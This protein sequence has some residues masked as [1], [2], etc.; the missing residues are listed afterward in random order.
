M[1]GSTVT[2]LR[3][4]TC[5]V[6]ADQVGDA[7]YAPAAGVTVSFAVTS[8][9][10]PPGPPFVDDGK[11]TVR[12]IDLSEQHVDGQLI[13]VKQDVSKAGARASRSGTVSTRAGSGINGPSDL[14]VNGEYVCTANIV[15]GLGSCAVKIK[16]KGALTFYAHYRG[17]VPTGT[18]PV[19]AS[20]TTNAPSNVATVAINT[21]S[22]RVT[23]K[24]CRINLYMYG[25]VFDARRVVTVWVLKDGK[26]LRIARVR[27]AKN[28]TWKLKTRMYQRTMTVRVS[29][30]RS[31]NAP[32][33]IRLSKVRSGGLAPRGC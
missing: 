11:A 32:Y 15:N 16:W 22:T 31:A 25:R 1:S 18:G 21:P 5:M 13:N 20:A 29:D 3:V 10:P 6:T 12:F 4:G 27:S 7:T 17:V 24:G 23:F 33:K 26:W 28:R 8:A 19:Q 14:Y 2:L 30:G 9:S